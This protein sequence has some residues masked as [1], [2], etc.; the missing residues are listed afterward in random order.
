VVTDQAMPGL[1]GVQLAGMIRESWPDLPVLLA[2]GYADIPAGADK[3]LVRL[4][5]P[6]RQDTLAQAIM[7]CMGQRG[8]RLKVVPFRPKQG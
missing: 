2:T 4:N 7:E 3:S 8:D 5:K 6:F 1:T